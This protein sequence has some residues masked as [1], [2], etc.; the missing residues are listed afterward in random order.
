MNELI[1]YG[2]EPF[3]PADPPL[4]P[5]FAPVP[6]KIRRAHGWTPTRQR[7]FIEALADSGSVTEAARRV[8]MTPEAAYYLRRAE[9]AESFR[10]AWE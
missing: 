6:R 9:G 3:E 7:D 10:A 2:D 8:N 1:R 4:I 5:D